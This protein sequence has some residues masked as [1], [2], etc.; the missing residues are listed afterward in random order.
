MSKRLI[1]FFFVLSSSAVSLLAQ[2][3]TTVNKNVAFS[4]YIAENIT[5]SADCI[6][7]FYNILTIFKDKNPRVYINYNNLKCISQPEEYYYT[8][9]NNPVNDNVEESWKLYNQLY[10]K[11]N[12]IIAYIRLEDHK[13]DKGARG[14]QMIEEMETLIEGL[15]KNRN[16]LQKEIYAK[17]KDIKQD[18]PK[19]S[20][21]LLL[22][23]I[24]HEEKVLSHL[25]ANHQKGAVGLDEAY[26]NTSY[27]DTEEVLLKFKT[28]PDSPYPASSYLKSILD[29]VEKLQKLK[30]SA[31]DKNNYIN[32]STTNYVNRTYKYY[33]DIFNN[34]VISFSKLYIQHYSD[35]KWSGAFL[36][37]KYIPTY[38]LQEYTIEVSVKNES[39]K[40]N[41][42][43]PLE[44]KAQ[45]NS[46]QKDHFYI[47]N[48][49]VL[50]L[51]TRT[52]SINSLDNSLKNFQTSLNRLKTRDKATL[53]RA[54][55][56]FNFDYYIVPENDLAIYKK[57]IPTLFPAY[58]KSL[59]TQINTIQEIM[60]EGERLFEELAIYGSD[61][62][63][64]NGDF[65]RPEEILERLSV[66][67]DT[68]DSKKE[69]LYND[70]RAIYNSYKVNNLANPWKVTSNA[71][72][73]AVDAEK[74]ILKN[75]KHKFFDEN[76]SQISPQP[77]LD[78]R[79][80]LIA[81]QSKYMSGI[82]RIGKN[83]GHCPYNPYERMPD[84]L[85]RMSNELLEI[86]GYIEK[87]QFDKYREY[88][89]RYNELTEDY[90][91]FAFLGKGEVESAL[92]DTNRPVFILSQTTALNKSIVTS[93]KP[94]VSQNIPIAEVETS[95]ND[96]EFT[97]FKGF[98]HNNLVFLLDVSGSM[99][100][101]D[102]LPLLKKSI[103]YLVSLM[104]PEDE[105]SIVV[106]SGKAQVTLHPSSAVEKD[107]IEEIIAKLKSEGKT[108]ANDGIKLAYKTAK[109]NFK[110][111]GNNR[112]ILATDGE[113]EISNKSK[114]LVEKY[115][116]Q[117]IQLSVFIFGSKT[118]SNNLQKLS[119]VG[120]GNFNHITSKNSN[121]QMIR[122][123]KAKN[124][125]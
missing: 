84:E 62:K 103:N 2:S 107:K 122:E 29:G 123:A 31:V 112:I 52:R 48:D 93:K 7:S 88:V 81:N 12:E 80:D 24:T 69:R 17:G 34:E 41:T 47:L 26:I 90:N 72:L 100:K 32:K 11:N 70:I 61:K 45:P 104:R 73:K 111:N 14:F 102:K 50:S 21:Q 99:R 53:N 3:S 66:L 30:K 78:T 4:D 60:L 6:Q 8:E 1:T 65:S 43:P 20:Y 35:L 97:S 39:F 51:N 115:S 125:N 83:N 96:Q 55:L 121:E 63:F 91:K 19:K 74:D 5:K 16:I 58:S 124:V 18:N 76:N 56:S 10:E 105:I 86:D 54:R 23:L 106:Y 57:Q 119:K 37:P 13:T 79:R 44:I 117:N 9:A 67:F 120:E 25:D 59:L 113:L 82:R 22:D 68:Y 33:L 109:D 114:N 118:T 40:D 36:Y 15:I 95:T 108:N 49:Y 71:M 46:L 64:I 87:K 101:E 116:E 38:R 85:E 75:V 42:V 110:E 98:P 89:Y 77:L 94:I 27:L 92:N 28:L